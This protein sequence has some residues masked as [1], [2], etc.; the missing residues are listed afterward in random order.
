MNFLPSGRAIV[1]KRLIC[2]NSITGVVLTPTNICAADN[3]IDN[4]SI[5]IFCKLLKC[6]FSLN[7]ITSSPSYLFILLSFYIIVL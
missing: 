5:E 2:S 6:L 4:R 1:P 3:L 7:E